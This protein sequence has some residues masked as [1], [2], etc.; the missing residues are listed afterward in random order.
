[1]PRYL[2][3]C[4]SCSS[5]QEVWAGME[6]KDETI[7]TTKCDSCGRHQLKQIMAQLSG[8]RVYGGAAD[9]VPITEA[10]HA[11][12]MEVKQAIEANPDLGHTLPKGRDKR[13]DPDHSPKY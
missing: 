3:E 11:R 1:M 5:Q 8:F 12:R 7:A 6:T 4:Q 13:Y 9:E 2:T 10:S